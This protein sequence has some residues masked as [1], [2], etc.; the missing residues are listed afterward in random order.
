MI[1]LNTFLQVL[2]GTGF[3]FFMTS[4][5]AA[6][7]F[8]FRGAI[9]DTMNRAFLG[10]ASGVMMAA[11]VW[12][13]LIPSI[14]QSG[15]LGMAPWFPPSLGFVFGGVFLYLADKM[16]PWLHE[17][18]SPGAIDS[19]A[20]DLHSCESAGVLEQPAIG[21]HSLPKKGTGAKLLV[22]A[23]TA[24]NIPEGMAVGLAFVLA[25]QHP[26]DPA[27]LASAIG[28]AAGIGIQNFPEGAAISLPVRQ[29]GAS[30]GKAFLTGCL[31]G[32][33]EP[34]AGI[35]VFLTAAAVVPLM[36][37]L[38]AFAGGAMIYVVADEL[39]PQAQPDETSNVGTIG[40]MVGFLVMMILDVAL[41]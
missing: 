31:S 1:N 27:Y 17:S 3:T 6:V 38:L 39:I 12:S 28:L 24:H 16:L 29:S 25:G 35:L 41:G 20:G 30:V 34:L 10:F 33:V 13:L 18:S 40:V 32:I 37:W 23:V 4:L 36:P 11:S 21:N 9:S 7:V 26:G 19:S 22:L 15:E 2:L 5:G 8:C 14:E